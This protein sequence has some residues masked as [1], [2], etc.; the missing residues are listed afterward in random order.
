[1]RQILSS[2]GCTMKVI[3]WEDK[4]LISKGDKHIVLVA[5]VRVHLGG[6]QLLKSPEPMPAHSQVFSKPVRVGLMCSGDMN[7][8]IQQNNKS[9]Y[10]RLS[11]YAGS[12][13]WSIEPN[14]REFNR[15]IHFSKT[16]VLSWLIWFQKTSFIDM[17]CFTFQKFSRSASWP[18]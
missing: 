3:T 9:F 11:S 2:P 18:R 16:E 5:Q 4:A 6:W 13:A 8:E 7:S 10:F 12:W 17:G 15:K 1:M 14:L